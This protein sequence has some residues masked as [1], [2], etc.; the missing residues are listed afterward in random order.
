MGERPQDGFG[1]K[2]GVRLPLSAE[3]VREALDRILASSPFLNAQRPSQFLSFIVER[4]LAGEEDGIKEYLIGVDVFRRSQDYDPKDDPVVRI[5]AGRLRKKLAEYYSGP[6]KD[7]AVI[8]ELP[9]GGYV[10]LFTARNQATR[11]QDAVPQTP[12][13]VDAEGASRRKNTLPR[14]AVVALILLVAGTLAFTF[15][16]RRRIR[17]APT[18]IAVLPFMKLST[19]SQG[20]YLGDGV[21]EDLTTGLAAMKGLRV[22]A[23]TSA[24][25]FRGNSE[26]VRKIGQALNAQALLEGSIAPSANGLRI[27]A[28]LIDARNGYH[29]WAKAYDVSA[30]D[31][32]ASE[33][34]IVLQTA[35][36]LGVPVNQIPP[37]KRDTENAEAHDLYLRGRYLWSKRDLPDMQESARL[38]QRAVQEDS[39]Y[40]LAYSGLAD[41]Y[42]VMAINQQMPPAEAVPRARAALQRALELDPNLAQ[43]HATLGL[44]KS[45]C[46]WD[47]QGGEK[48]FRKAIELQPNYAEAHHWAG[49]NL[50]LMGQFA[51][52]EAELRQAQVLDPLSFMITEGL[53]ENYFFSRRYD[54]AIATAE[55][56]PDRR[57]GWPGL[58]SAYIFKGM[59]D[60]SQ[61]VIPGGVSPNDPNRLLLKAE[62]LALSGHPTQAR[63][64][65]QEVE[66]KRQDSGTESYVSAANLAMSYAVI[67]EKERAFQWLDKAYQQHDPILA[68]LK[69]D[70]GFDSLR[71]DP[72]YLDLLGKI[73]LSN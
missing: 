38:F 14:V 26:D 18:S 62:A 34:D 9:K 10:P 39:H 6:G 69:V 19:G 15:Y 22:V 41:A 2:V 51:A 71:S 43:G 73:G 37:I 3:S 56:I 4:T 63:E 44:L 57:I 8:I 23:A 48:E 55:K 25:Q 64:I 35:R 20:E 65:M 58:A 49:L 32:M 24:F 54:E 67:G 50:M 53:L 31:L 36:V 16:Q 72:R 33:E 1:V 40:A 52:A 61:R 66:R 59:Y 42:T 68:Q 17:T 45:Q 11:T 27:N 28:Q 5:E 7:D 13:T 30:A 21:A 12:R 60:E 46:E 47:W 29:L 70:P